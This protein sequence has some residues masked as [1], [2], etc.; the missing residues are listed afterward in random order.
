MAIN[1]LKVRNFTFSSFAVLLLVS[2]CSGEVDSGQ[3][4]AKSVSLACTIDS[5]ASTS[6]GGNAEPV[7]VPG[8]Q[9]WLGGTGK[10]NISSATRIVVEPSN[11]PGL[12]GVADRLSSDLK[13]VTGLDLP[14]VV[15]GNIEN[16]DIALSLS[17]C[18]SS[19]ARKIGAEGYTL[20][21]QKG[22]VLRA[23][24]GMDSTGASGIFYATRTLLQMLSL[25]GAKAGQHRSLDQGYVTD[26]PN[27]AER[28]VMIDVGRNFVDKSSLEAYMRFM[29]EYKI[30]NL[31]LHLSDDLLNVETKP[32]SVI[33]AAFRLHSSNAN[34]ANAPLSDDGLY[35]SQSDWNELEDIASENGVNIIPEID[36]PAHARAMVKAL[37]G[38]GETLDLSKPETLAYVKSVWNEFLPWFRSSKVHLGGDESG[39]PNTQAYLNALIDFLQSKGKVVEMWN[40]SVSTPTTYPSSVVITSWRNFGPLPF[41]APG[42]KWVNA[43]G[44][45]YGGPNM[46][47]LVKQYYG[48]GLEESA[49]FAGDSFYANDAKLGIVH[50]S[51]NLKSLGSTGKNIPEAWDWFGNLAALGVDS[52]TYP[53]GGKVSLWHDAAYNRPFSFEGLSNYLFADVIPAAGQIWWSG[54]RH[55]SNGMLVPYS[56]LRQSVG[57]FQYGPGNL[58]SEMFAAAPLS[59]TSPPNFSSP[60][61]YVRT[62]EN[63]ATGGT[64]SGGAIVGKCASCGKGNVVGLNDTGELTL[65]IS[66]PTAGAYLVPIEYVSGGAISKTADVSVNGAAATKQTFP[67]SSVDGLAVARIGMFANLRAGLNDFK[68]SRANDAQ[69]GIAGVERPIIQH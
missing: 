17:P 13:E 14:V 57:I 31:H 61:V 16:S 33:V 38:N 24:P 18:S 9:S 53:L 43:S 64:L 21:V 50:P 68:F 69:F 28:S 4:P 10:W 35:Y 29:G 59:T 22:V 26:F 60:P 46:D 12:Q 52:S 62:P 6:N 36:T 23:N 7:V 67:S 40:D 15:S 5:A 37:G 1:L 19:V 41:L 49:G 3:S 63:P 8:V 58:A 48:V 25:D 54:Q 30:N 65:T 44:S 11:V 55:D 51:V 42:S 34:F 2:G 32:S 45:F 27:V 39:D 56:T 20:A 66:V 47:G